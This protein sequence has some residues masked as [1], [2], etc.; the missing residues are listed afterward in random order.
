MPRNTASK[1]IN[2]NYKIWFD[3]TILL[4]SH[5]SLF[6]LFGLLWVGI[7]ILIWIEDR[8]PVFY[9]QE[10]VGK[11]R[12]VIFVLKFRTMVKDAENKGP[13]WTIKDDPRVTKVGRILRKT[14]LDELP[15]VLN[16]LRREM[17]FVGPRALDVEEQHSLERLIPGFEKRLQTLPGLTGLAQVYDPNDDAYD[18]LKLDSEYIENMGPRLDL[19]LLI[20]SLRNTLVA[21]WDKRQGKPSGY[22]E[23]TGFH[24]LEDQESKLTDDDNREATNGS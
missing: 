16:I 23:M 17:S 22:G 18:K 12:R 15:E 7:P 19:K 13:S 14:A 21:R 9:R 6:P 8:G 2:G 11:D 5:L 3:L 1:P 4:L 10:R 20:L 24:I